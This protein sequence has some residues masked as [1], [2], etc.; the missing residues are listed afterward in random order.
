M[1]MLM[2]TRSNEPPAAELLL[3]MYSLYPDML[4]LG[5]YGDFRVTVVAGFSMLVPLYVAVALL[6]VRIQ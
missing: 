3:E 4:M 5:F 6:C 2:F 1:L